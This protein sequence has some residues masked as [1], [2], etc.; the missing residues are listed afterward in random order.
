MRRG[1]MW[2][3]LFGAL[4]VTSS[5]IVA[6]EGDREI[7]EPFARFEPMIGSWKGTGVPT[8]NRLKGWA[9]THVW[10]WKFLKGKPV[11]MTLEFKGDKVLTQA[12]LSYDAE[13][14]HYLLEGTDAAGKPVT[15]SGAMDKAGKALVLN[16][17]GAPEGTGKDRVTIR[18]N[19]NLIRY[20]MEFDR[21]EP[22]APQFKRVVDVGLTKEGESFAAGAAAANLPKCI[23]T[24]GAATMSVSYQGKSYPICCSGCRDEFNENPEKYV[25]IAAL[26]TTTEGKASSKP[27]SANVGKDD[28]SFEGL[29]EGEKPKGREPSSTSASRPKKAPKDETPPASKSATAAK[30]PAKAAAQA[31]RLGQGLEKSGKTEA[32]LRYYR[33]V[34]KDFPTTPQAKTAAA[35]L[36]V[37]EKE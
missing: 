31:L 4:L 1:T 27:P 32:A 3:G 33:Q 37:L 6:G 22:G 13:A 12:Q 15:Y 16:R 24:G 5:A 8:A 2:V 36:K 7:P 9:E 20:T 29:D 30:D 11:G 28:G 35:R 26:M 17:S 10:A 19:S 23:L 34:V 25:K 18:P 21:Q 14:K